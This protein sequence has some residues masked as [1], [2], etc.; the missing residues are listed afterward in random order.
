VFRNFKHLRRLPAGVGIWL[1]DAFFKVNRAL[2]VHD[3]DGAIRPVAGRNS[4][5]RPP[6]AHCIPIP[7]HPPH[8]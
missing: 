7:P 3:F 6:V 8:E 4:D 2:S 1:R 5:Q